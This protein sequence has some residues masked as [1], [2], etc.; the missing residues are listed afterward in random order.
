MLELIEFIL[1]CVGLSLIITTSKLFKPFR[2]WC[3]KKS[4]LIGYL[5]GCQLC[6]GLWSGFIVYYLYKLEYI[7]PY[8]DIYLGELINFGFIGSFVSYCIY[9]LLCPLI[10]KYD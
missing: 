3:K 10:K 6:F 5:V 8:V 2:G 4:K 9:L 1:S 7:I